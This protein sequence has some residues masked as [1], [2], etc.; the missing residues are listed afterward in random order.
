M[1]TRREFMYQI[2]LIESKINIE[3]ALCQHYKAPSYF[4]L[5]RGNDNKNKRIRAQCSDGIYRR[6]SSCRCSYKIENI[7]VYMWSCFY[8]VR[9]LNI[10]NPKLLI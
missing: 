2:P 5:K 9:K 6:K 7:E 8:S 1:G 4:R 10:H 3:R